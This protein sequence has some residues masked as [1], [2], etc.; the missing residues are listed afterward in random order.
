MLVDFDSEAKC[1]VAGTTTSQGIT[2]SNGTIHKYHKGAR[3]AAEIGSPPNLPQ[4]NR[5]G[6]CRLLLAI[7]HTSGGL[8]RAKPSWMR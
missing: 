1:L 7:R 6:D 2:L 3:R 4:G 5:R 8:I